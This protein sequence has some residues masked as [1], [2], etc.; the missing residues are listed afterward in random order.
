LL[1]TRGPFNAHLELLDQVIALADARGAG[2][3]QLEKLAQAL[4]GRAEARRTRGRFAESIADCQR[5]LSLARAAGDRRVEGRVLWNMGALADSEGR[6]EEAIEI[7]QQALVIQQEVGDRVAEGK[8]YGLLGVITLWL[9]RYDESRSYLERAQIVLHEQENHY[10]AVFLGCLAAVNQETGALN[11]ARLQYERAIERLREIGARRHVGMF[12]GYLGGLEWEQ[13]REEK[14]RQRLNEA[15]EIAREVGD[16][17]HVALF[18][19]ILAAIDAC[20]DR[21]HDAARGFDTAAAILHELEEKDLGSGEPYRTAIELHRS[22]LDVALSRRAELTGPGEEAVRARAA[23]LSRINE[24]Q[25]PNA[26]TAR[27]DDV[28]FALR[29]LRRAMEQ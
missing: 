4:L 26:P 15:L 13:H 19:A 12:L 2:H 10:E 1:S 14:G 18:V 7:L 6:V 27:S 9:A 5:A 22:H 25:D 21:L 24:A 23:A 17:V 11:E 20:D 28:R 3:V 16:R 29:M 8:S